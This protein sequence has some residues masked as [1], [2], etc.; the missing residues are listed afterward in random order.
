MAPLELTNVHSSVFS[1]VAVR[2]YVKIMH[3]N[4]TD[5]FLGQFMTTAPTDRE[6]ASSEATFLNIQ[7]TR[8]LDLNVGGDRKIFVR[9][10]MALIAWADETF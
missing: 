4:I 5:D 7:S 10:L 3:L 6:A 8:W 1:I 2:H 9:H